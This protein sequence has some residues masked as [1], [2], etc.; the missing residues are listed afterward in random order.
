MKDILF[1]NLPAIWN[2]KSF[3]VFSPYKGEIVVLSKQEIKDERV[4]E[5]L[6]Q[7][8]FFG[9]PNTQRGNPNIIRIVLVVTTNCRLKCKYCYTRGGEIRRSMNLN[10][11]ISAINAAYNEKIKTANSI[12]VLFFGGEPT[13]NFGLIK[14]VTNYVKKLPLQNKY[15]SIAVD[16]LLA[17]EE[18]DWLIREN[19]FLSVSCDGPPN[20]Q[21]FLRRGTDGQP[22][23]DRV[24]KTIKK[25]VRHKTLFNVRS[26]ITNKNLRLGLLV[27]YLSSLG[28]KF[29][30]FERVAIAGRA[31]KNDQVNHLDYIKEFKKALAIANERQVYLITSPLMNLFSPADYFCIQFSQAKYIVTPAGEI[32]SCYFKEMAEYCKIGKVSDN[33]F[34]FDLEKKGKLLRLGLPDDCKA[35]AF[36]FICSGGCPADN[37][38]ATGGYNKV[39][40]TM[41]AINKAI[42]HEAIIFIF[43][44]KGRKFSPIFGTEILERLRESK[45]FIN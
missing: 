22:S 24:E 11:A 29:I 33:G 17:E 43:N 25:L 28:V 7:Q 44:N 40:K 34:D 41:C 8:N 1:H 14:E 9:Q 5:K 21:D 10:M 15:F 13:L 45:Q 4:A 39:N 2:G 19:F 16:G 18:L 36:K 3:L 35:C 37:K 32:V 23:S 6:T 27:D 42:I 30:H 31:K 20:V 38:L 12:E 26:T